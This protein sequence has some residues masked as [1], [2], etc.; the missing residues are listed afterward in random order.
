VFASRYK[1]SV[2][3]PP[4]SWSVAEKVMVVPPVP[5]RGALIESPPVVPVTVSVPVVSGLISNLHK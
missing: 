1:E 3:A 5:P 4:S 2:P